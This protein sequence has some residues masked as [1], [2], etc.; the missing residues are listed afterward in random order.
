MIEEKGT[1]NIGA[2]DLATKSIAFQTDVSGIPIV[3]ILVRF[4]LS[5]FCI[6]KAVEEEFA[7]IEKKICTGEMTIKNLEDKFFCKISTMNLGSA[8]CL[9]RLKCYFYKSQVLTF[10]CDNT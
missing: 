5:L 9:E 7:D 8:K 6:Q 1:Q 2:K 4:L 10:F 3:L